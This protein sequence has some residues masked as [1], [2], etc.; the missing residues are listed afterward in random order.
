[1]DPA[2]ATQLNMAGM[3]IGQHFGKNNALKPFIRPAAGAVTEHF[4]G[5][6]MGG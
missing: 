1:M 2:H 4:V 6:P 3:A 5:N